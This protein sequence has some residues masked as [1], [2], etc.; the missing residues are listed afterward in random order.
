MICRGHAYPL[1]RIAKKLR[2]F[3]DFHWFEVTL[4]SLKLTAK[5]HENPHLSW[6]LYHEHGGFSW[7]MLVYRRV[8]MIMKKQ[9]WNHVYFRHGYHA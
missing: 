8:T 3:W 6:D 5:A 7:A 9:P 2:R 4:P 1:C